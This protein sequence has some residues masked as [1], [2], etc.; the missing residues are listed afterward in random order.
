MGSGLE[1]RSQK[2]E[3]PF[4]LLL[5]HHMRGIGD[6]TLGRRE[7]FAVDGAALL[8]KMRE[9]EEIDL[10][11]SRPLVFKGVILLA[12][13]RHLSCEC[14]ETRARFFV[15]HL[16]AGKLLVGEL[17]LGLH[18]FELAIEIV[19]SARP[20]RKEPAQMPQ[21]A[22]RQAEKE[23]ENGVFHG[24]RAATL[25]ADLSNKGSISRR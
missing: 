9:L 22:G 19:G 10:A 11:R 2:P 24:C 20:L 6:Q 21:Q 3:I 23:D 7:T 17:Q 4:P 15:D 8:D 5:R 12:H 13:A 1:D 18:P 25:T 14:E 16:D